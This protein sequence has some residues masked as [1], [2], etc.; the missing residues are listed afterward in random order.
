MADAKPTKA[1]PKARQKSADQLQHL[2]KIKTFD[3]AYR[4]ILQVKTCLI[5]GSDKSDLPSLW[6]VVDLPERQPG[7][8]GW[9][10]KVEAIWAW[11]N[12]L[13]ATY[14]EEI[15][16]GKLPGGLAM[17]MCM[18]HLRNVHYP[19]H[20]RPIADCSA[21]ARRIYELVRTEPHTTPQIREELA[22]TTMSKISKSRVDTALVELQ[23]SLNIVRSNSPRVKN[24]TW[25][26][27]V[28]QH[29]GFLDE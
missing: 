10:E 17:L 7:Q 23:T 6:E 5:F 24:D 16:Y 20:H 29:P 1:T 12:E 11:K 19:A 15:F 14:P 3:Q 18:D 25:L 4:F 8:K 2:P 27:L 26:P 13:P 9:G 22:S 21:L 28:E